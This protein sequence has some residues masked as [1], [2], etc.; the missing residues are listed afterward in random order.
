MEKLLNV[1]PQE[2]S[3]N[4]ELNKQA[5]SSI[6]LSNRTQ[7][8]VAFK[9]M[10][11]SPNKYCVLPNLGIVL[12]GSNCDLIVTM[13][14]PKVLLPKVQCTDK[15]LIKSVLASPGATT[16]DGVGKLFE[17]EAGGHVQDCKL[18]VIYTFPGQV[19]PSIADKALTSSLSSVT[20]HTN[21]YNPKMTMRKLLEI[22]PSKLHFPFELKKELSC[23][24]HLSNMTERHVLFKVKTTDPKKYCVQPNL[25]TVLPRSTCVV[26]V[27]MQA[28]TTIP[29]DRQ[30]KDKFLIQSMVGN[31]GATDRKVT[32]ELFDETGRSVEEVKLRVVYTFPSQPQSLATPELQEAYSSSVIPELQEKQSN[33]PE[34]VIQGDKDETSLGHL[35]KKGIITGLLGLIIWHLIMKILPLLWSLTFVI[36]MLVIKMINNLVSNSVEEWIVKILVVTMKF[37]AGLDGQSCKPRFSYLSLYSVAE[38]CKW[39]QK[40][41]YKHSR[42]L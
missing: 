36:M 22:Q 1:E 38:K 19:P 31:P 26:I 27:R 13:R 17:K 6:R 5:S 23:V 20:E 34:Q 15:F 33:D 28:Q 39:K 16:E 2:L 29:L 35:F 18:K 4:Y 40:S 42:S 11:T 8:H 32:P 12:P 24:L 10:T 30:C 7:K 41:F 9:V 3:F 21:L 37:K 25:G 14:G